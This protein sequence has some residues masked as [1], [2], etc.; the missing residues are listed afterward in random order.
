MTEIRGMELRADIK[1]KF[2][3]L[4]ELEGTLEANI[5]IYI[6]KLLRQV[7]QYDRRIELEELLEI[8]SA[9]LRDMEPIV[10]DL[11]GKGKGGFVDPLDSGGIVL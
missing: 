10:N 9:S 1:E 8:P 4:E 5:R 6:N 7:R 11:D 2:S 3:V